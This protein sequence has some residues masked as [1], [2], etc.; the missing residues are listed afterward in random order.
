MK[1]PFLTMLCA[2]A[3][4]VF[5]PQAEACTRAV[6]LGPDGMTVTGRTMDWREDPLTN[7]YIFP[8][9]VVRR[10]ANTDKT[11]FWT[12]KYGSLS[13]AGYDIGITDG[14]NE[15][16]LVANLLFL[17][18]SVY[19]RPGDTRP[20]MGLSVWTQYVLDNFATWMRPWPNFR[21]RSSASTL[22]TCPTACSRGSTWRFPILRATARSSSIATANW[23]STTDGSIR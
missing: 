21:R 6:Y 1:T 22:P 9:G 10:G 15:A 23:K 16:G 13:A 17:P 12:S 3:L 8:R 2:A 5:P 7:L 4:A 20:V 14:M 18:E 11:V 19:E